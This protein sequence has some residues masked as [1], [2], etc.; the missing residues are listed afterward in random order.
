MSFDL[1]HGLLILL[2]GSTV[3]I[4]A[5][6]KLHKKEKFEKYGDLQVSQA[7]N[8]GALKK[9]ANVPPEETRLPADRIEQLRLGQTEGKSKLEKMNDLIKRDYSTPIDFWGKVVDQNGNPIPNVKATIVIDGQIRKSEHLVYS[10]EVGR[11]EL[12]GK[13]GARARVKVSLDGYAPTA[14]KEIGSDVSSRTIY[15]AT[16]AMPAYAPPTREHPQVFVLRKRNP[17]AS[18]AHSESKD[19][20]IEKAGEPEKVGLRAGTRTI[21]VE[22]RCWSS[23]PAPFT[24]EKYDWRAEIKVLGGKLRSI[25]EFD[26]VIAPTHGYQSV[27]KLEMPKNM[28]GN[29]IRSS[30]NG[31]RD[32]WI[33][34]DDGTYGKARVEVKTGRTHEVDAE[35]WYN[36]DGTNSFEQ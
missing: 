26:P 18:I 14:D 28:E 3:A 16:K 9:P 31:Q 6:P 20:P 27:F 1:R 25:T 29:W 11:F 5:W 30:P 19:V 17:P 36:L 23:C 22:V 2:F 24:Y 33:Q 8:S 34:F 10:D 4:W 7:P 12:L 21:E 32:F 15:Y 13:R 35:V